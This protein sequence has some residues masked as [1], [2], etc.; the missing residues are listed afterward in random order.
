MTKDR[1]VIRY[2]LFGERDVPSFLDMLRYDGCTVEGWDNAAGPSQRNWIVRLRSNPNRTP[3]YE[4]TPQRWDSFGL[5][6]KE[7]A[8][9]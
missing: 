4:F 6:L 3:G 2:V 5:T 1:T 7:R 8:D 9:A